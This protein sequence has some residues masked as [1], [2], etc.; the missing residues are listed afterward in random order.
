MPMLQEQLHAKLAGIYL[1]GSDHTNAIEQLKAVIRDQPTDPLAYYY[2]GEL[3]NEERR[4]EEAM[5][6]FNKAI[7][8]KSDFE[9][10]YYGLAQ[11]Q[12]S[13][14]KS[15]EALE[16]LET[17][18]K[19][20]PE[21]FALDYYSGVASSE[22]NISQRPKCWPKQPSRSCWIGVFI[23]SL[24]PRTSARAITSTPNNTSRNA[25]NF[26]RTGPRPVI[27]WDTC[28]PTVE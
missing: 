8:L 11:A 16:T 17:V 23:L 15:T 12:L 27:I 18:R 22:K 20:F 1:R 4:P 9:V 7:L 25:W 28:G 14:H 26:R 21:S 2:V 10:A 13:L 5:D 24:A 6:Y 3:C 19:K